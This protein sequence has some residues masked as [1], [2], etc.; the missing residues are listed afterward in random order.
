[1]VVIVNYPENGPFKY[2]RSLIGHYTQTYTGDTIVQSSSTAKAAWR[3]ITHRQS[4]EDHPSSE[5]PELGA[6]DIPP[7]VF[8]CS[9]EPSAAAQQKGRYSD[10]VSHIYLDWLAMWFVSVGDL[11]TRA[12]YTYT[13][14][15]VKYDGS[16]DVVPSHQ[17]A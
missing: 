5:V 9:I 2:S 8:F 3:A 10:I 1:M 15:R 7:P 13:C 14:A 4:D 12:S 16:V 11:A 17:I 6:I